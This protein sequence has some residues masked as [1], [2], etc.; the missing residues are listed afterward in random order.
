MTRNEAA[1]LQTIAFSELG[2]SLLAQSDRGY[3]VLF[4]GS[5]FDSYADHPRKKITVNGLTSTAAGKYQ[6]LEKVYDAYKPQLGLTDFS[7]H[8][9]DC[10]ALELFREVGADMLI[11][12]GHFEEAITKCSL[13]WAS[14]PGAK[15]DQHKN[16]MVYLKAFYENVGGTLA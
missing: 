14:L 8:A 7:P 15:W 4:G 1:L 6:I 5:K 10:I 2:R 13:R 11:N 16:S 12:D 9:Q 3:N